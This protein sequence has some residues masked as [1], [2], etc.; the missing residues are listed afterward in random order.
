MTDDHDQP[1]PTDLEQLAR[2]ITM[3]GSVGRH[4]AQTI[5]EALRRLAQSSERITPRP[6]RL[7]AHLTDARPATPN[8]QR[9]RLVS[10]ADRYEVRR[11]VESGLTFN[12]TACRL[13]WSPS[14]IQS[15][16]RA[17]L[18]G[19]NHRCPKGRKRSVARYSMTP[20]GCAG[21][22][23][24]AGRS[25]ADVADGQL[26]SCNAASYGMKGRA[27]H[28][29]S[30]ERAIHVDEV[31]RRLAA[32]ESMGSIGR[33]LGHSSSGDLEGGCCTEG[34]APNA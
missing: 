2:S 13:I 25:I 34:K 3:D 14:T 30:T 32:G 28:D 6:G 8:A 11:L 21:Q 31:R 33:A 16:P 29:M 4:D 27:S 1:T 20:T 24:N 19:C 9:R 12:E 15:I 17:C 7:E 23:P 26:G 22:F 5:A 18:W 10:D